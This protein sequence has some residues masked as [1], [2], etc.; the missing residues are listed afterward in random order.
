MLIVRIVAMAIVV[1]YS[2]ICAWSY[3]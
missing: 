2:I 1:M 3:R